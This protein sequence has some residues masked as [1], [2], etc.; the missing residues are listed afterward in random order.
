[1][2]AS[3]KMVLVQLDAMCF[4]TAKEPQGA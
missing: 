1:M 3:K 4:A 2:P